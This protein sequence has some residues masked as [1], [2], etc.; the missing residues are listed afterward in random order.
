MGVIDQVGTRAFGGF[1][2]FGCSWGAVKVAEPQAMRWHTGV[3]AGQRQSG[4]AVG[5]DLSLLALQFSD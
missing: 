4:G 1:A 2:E 5:G 3:P